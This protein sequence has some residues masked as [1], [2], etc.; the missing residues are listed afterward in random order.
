[1]SEGDVTRVVTG[2]GDVPRIPAI[3]AMHGGEPPRTW[4]AY[5]GMAGEIQGRLIQHFVRR[6]SSVVTRSSAVGVNID[7]VRHVEWWE[8]PA[9]QDGDRLHAAELIAFE[10]L[11]PALRSR[12]NPRRA[13]VLLSQE[14]E[15]RIT[16]EPLFK[17]PPAGRLTLPMLWDTAA[18]LQKLEGR[19]EELEARVRDLET[20]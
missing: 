9:F 11:D 1:M 17:G 18:H 14:P 20:R 10:V 7:F 6:D 2:W 8:H 15:F 16:M 12:G 3:Y 19:V 5:V 4:V 13:A